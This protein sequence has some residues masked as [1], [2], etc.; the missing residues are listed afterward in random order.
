MSRT[1]ERKIMLMKI[2]NLAVPVRTLAMIFRARVKRRR[3]EEKKSRNQEKPIS[4]F[5]FRPH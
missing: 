3:T 5:H 2:A 1:P 4:H